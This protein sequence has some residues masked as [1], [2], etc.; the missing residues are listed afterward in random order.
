ANSLDNGFG[1]LT[2]DGG[3]PDAVIAVPLVGRN[4]PDIQEGQTIG[5][6]TSPATDTEGAIPQLPNADTV[7]RN[8]FAFV[9]DDGNPTGPPAEDTTT[10]PLSPPSEGIDAV[11]PTVTPT[12]TTTVPPSNGGTPTTST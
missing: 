4:A 10:P 11:P 9:D 6:A 1:N 8:V 5:D 3:T 7:D 2:S 12:P